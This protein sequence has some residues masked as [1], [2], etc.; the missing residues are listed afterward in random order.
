M[1]QMQPPKDPRE[2][3]A[4]WREKHPDGAVDYDAATAASRRQRLSDWA[5]DFSAQTPEDVARNFNGSS[6]QHN[7]ARNKKAAPELPVWNFEKKFTDKGEDPTSPEPAP[8]IAPKKPTPG[9][10]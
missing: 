2:L 1:P 5:K 6:F 8:A 3:M 4:A 10:P 7:L 9:A